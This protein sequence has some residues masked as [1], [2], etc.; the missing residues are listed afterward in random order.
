MNKNGVDAKILITSLDS[1]GYAFYPWKS[2]ELLSQSIYSGHIDVSG[3][4]IL[5]V[6]S[7][8]SLT[9]SL[10]PALAYVEYLRLK[11]G[12]LVWYLRIETIP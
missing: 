8:T 6:F 12:L 7:I 9:S 4:R 11:M 1:G 10:V 5:E 2:A 3:R